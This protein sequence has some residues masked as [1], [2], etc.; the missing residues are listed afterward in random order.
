M[1]GLLDD[2]Y[3]ELFGS[4]CLIRFAWLLALFNIGGQV[5]SEVYL[6]IRRLQVS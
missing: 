1:V 2:A 6:V 3:S 5:L 4:F